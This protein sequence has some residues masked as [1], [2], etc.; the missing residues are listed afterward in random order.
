META[1]SF[2]VSEQNH[3]AAGFKKLEVSYSMN[4]IH[5]GNMKVVP[6]SSWMYIATLMYLINLAFPNQGFPEHR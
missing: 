2:Q 3:F 6:S 1:S 4:N 5:C